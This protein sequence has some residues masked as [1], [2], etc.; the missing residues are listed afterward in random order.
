MENLRKRITVGQMDPDE[1]VDRYVELVEADST[2]L[3]NF[4]PSRH[5]RTIGQAMS[6]DI[7]HVLSELTLAEK[8]ALVCGADLWHTVAIERLG[9]PAIMCSD[10]PHGLRAQSQAGPRRPARQRARH[11][12]PHG[13]GDRIVLGRRADP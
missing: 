5:P 12:L 10:G 7:E 3:V 1:V 6:F 4:I 11:M 2:E 13:L 8:A 9:V